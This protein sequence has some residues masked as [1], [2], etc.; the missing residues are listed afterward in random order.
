MH[1]IALLFACLAY[2]V[3]AR[4]VQVVKEDGLKAL[5]SLL[6]AHDTAAAF[7][8]AGHP[9]RFH[10]SNPSSADSRLA[11]R[12]PR[13]ECDDMEGDPTLS[14]ITN[15]DLGEKK[16]DIM[17]AMSKAVASALSK[18]ESFVAVH[19][20][21]GKDLIR[22]GTDAPAAIGNCWSLGSINKENNGALTKQVSDLLA[23]FGVT[24]DRIYINFFDM[25]RENLGYNGA[26]FAG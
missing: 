6:V 23:D 18:P 9:S 24:P 14:I 12:L 21:D 19:V 20:E 4:R 3:Q 11:A 13:M 15:V 2:T 25:A 16:M 17:K 8:F 5:A 7:N 1:K 26:T 22:G 10:S